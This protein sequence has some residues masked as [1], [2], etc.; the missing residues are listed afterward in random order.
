[1]NEHIIQTKIH[2]MFRGLTVGTHLYEPQQD[3]RIYSLWGIVLGLVLATALL[4]FFKMFIPYKLLLT[5]SIVL[6]F[7]ALYMLYKLF[8][9]K[10]WIDFQLNTCM[11]DMSVDT[12]TG[13]IIWAPVTV[14]N[15]GENFPLFSGKYEVYRFFEENQYVYDLVGKPSKDAAKMIRDMYNIHTDEFYLDVPKLALRFTPDS[16][17]TPE[18]IDFL[19]QVSTIYPGE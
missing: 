19:Y 15:T 17:T 4:T 13:T 10:S 11:E 12:Q 8:S 2:T 16:K 7:M 14:N 1:M 3:N 5:I 9:V 18:F 6:T